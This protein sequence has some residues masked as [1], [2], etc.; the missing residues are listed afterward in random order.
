MRS[1][2]WLLLL[3]CGFSC[4][5]HGPAARAATW[6]FNPTT[7]TTT[8]TGTAYLWSTLPNWNSL[9]DGSGTAPDAVPNAAD[10]VVF[11]V[12]GSNSLSGTYALGAARPV[13]S[14]TVNTSGASYITKNSGTSGGTFDL[15]VGGGGIALGP[16]AGSV[17][18]SF[19]TAPLASQRVLVRASGSS[20]PITNDSASLLSFQQY[21]DTTLA[22]GTS[23]ITVAANGAGGVSF[24]NGI[25]NGSTG[26]VALVINSAGSGTTSLL[27]SST[28]TYSGGTT[29]TS[30]VLY[31]IRNALGTGSLVINGGSYV[32]DTQQIVSSVTLTSGTVFANS[33]SAL[34]TG[35][36]TV[37][38]GQFISNGNARTSFNPFTLAGDL[39]LGGTFNLTISNTNQNQFNLGGATRTISVADATLS[40]QADVID[41]GIVKT[42]AGGLSL[43]GLNTY[44]GN[45]IV[46]QG[47]LSIASTAALPGWD[48]FGRY[49]VP[50]GARLGVGD[51]VSG[52]EIGTIL[53]TG[54]LS[55]GSTIAITTS[56]V[57]NTLS[58]A[59]N[60]IG[61]VKSGSNTLTLTASNTPTATTIAGGVLQVGDGGTAGSLSGDVAV[62]GS[63]AT[64]AF[65][66]SEDIVFSGTISGIGSLVKA[67]GG[68][69]VLAAANTLTGSTTVQG[70]RLQL[71]DGSAL[72]SST[73]VPVAGGTL[74]L[75]PA[76]RT[77][78][79]GLAPNAGGLTD[80]GNGMVTVASGLSAADLVTAIV[81]GRASGSWTGT[82][83]ITSSVAAANV[84]SSVPRAVG[85]LDNGGGSLTAA[86]A[87][88]GDTNLDWQVDVLDA[89]NVLTS[90]KFDTG[91]PATWAQ[92]DFN[93]D[94]FVDVLDAADFITTGLY[95]NGPYN[96]SSGVV[97]AVPE[98]AIPAGLLL[99]AASVAL[100][101]RGRTRGGG[102]GSGG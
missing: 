23:T 57:G 39:T 97:A 54:N 88:P 62:T 82:S 7:L 75:T 21:V 1:T 3:M 95:N 9:A 27:G 73:I 34:G 80:V 89:A 76:L 19:H 74:T 65:N 20:L 92:G 29:L 78:A 58:A 84:A 18:F 4:T 81:A 102:D 101:R 28:S 83:G 93:Y 42:G 40:I 64:L 10:D 67:G 63:T 36:I 16:S 96:P 26:K 86:Y 69:L 17:Y 38:G 68:T 91:D 8:T 35:P 37:S 90:G 53:G 61:L 94:G 49:T 13:N 79:G 11:N 44:S 15:S 50:S 2:A 41:G 60:G 31:P 71:G 59:V 43:S 66:R 33:N 24:L 6:W 72:G 85:W 51:G 52:A 70:G 25:N 14:L 48:T 55:A 98:P 22:S 5:L 87:A 99:V 12:T 47:T 100:F 77:T 32:S 56:T 46:A 45:T 30:G